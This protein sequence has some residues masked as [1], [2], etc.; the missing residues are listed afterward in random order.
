M[1][2]DIIASAIL[3]GIILL[4][5]TIGA[6]RSWTAEPDARPSAKPA[7][8]ATEWSAN[9]KAA[10]EAGM[11]QAQ[12]TEA[13][14][15]KPTDWVSIGLSTLT[16]V[17]VVLGVIARFSPQVGVLSNIAVTGVDI[18]KKVVLPAHVQASERQTLAWAQAGTTMFNVINE[19]SNDTKVGD[20]KAKFGDRWPAAALTVVNQSLEELGKTKA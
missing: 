7:A 11:K 12:A 3:L 16:V 2:K 6:S 20:L 18:I 5:G 8:T 10:F 1:K 9:E 14:A 19:V 17:G 13:T 4:V 15:P